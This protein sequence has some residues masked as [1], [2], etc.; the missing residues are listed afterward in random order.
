MGFQV[1]FHVAVVGL[2]F[3]DSYFHSKILIVAQFM[4]QNLSY[5]MRNSK[6]GHIVYCSLLS[7][8]LSNFDN[9]FFKLILMCSGDH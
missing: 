5:L 8:F 4:G 9:N 3:L 7:Q 6:Y 1:G 2:G